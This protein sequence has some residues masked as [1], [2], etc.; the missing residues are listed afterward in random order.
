MQ[1]MKLGVVGKGGVGKTTVAGLLARTY[2]DRGLRVLAVDTDSSPNLGQALGL[3]LSQTEDV[4]ALPRNVIT[5]GLGPAVD[6]LMSTYGRATPSGV[7]LLS[8]MKVAQ[9]GAGCSCGGHAT[10]RGLLGETVDSVDVTV[11]DMEA[12]LEH[13]SR[14]GGT[15]AYADLL[16]AV[17]E[18]SLKSVTTATRTAVL[19]AELGIPRVLVVGNKSRGAGD[20]EF[21]RSALG[22]A[23]LPLVGV[24]PECADLASADRTAAGGLVAV[25]RELQDVLDRVVAAVAD[26]PVEG[27]A[28][29]AVPAG[30]GG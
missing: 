13:L 26:S 20:E 9:A 16:L 19:A 1:P 2:A 25:P 24:L 14:S 23:G 12:G 22:E 21:L 30:E 7:T 27:S 29:T 5:G 4:P 15:L 17:C 3:S 10:V 11:V 8:A 28:V 18:P 6:D